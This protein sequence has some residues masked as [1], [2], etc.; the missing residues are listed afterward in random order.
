MVAIGSVELD[1]PVVLAPMAGVTDTVYRSICRRMGAGLVCSEMVSAEGLVHNNARTRTLLRTADDEHPVSMQMFGARPESMARAAVAAQE[2]GAD[3]IDVNAGC[4]TPKIVRNGAGAALLRDVPRLENILHAVVEYTE[5]PVTV[6]LRVGWDSGSVNVVEI[7]RRVEQCGVAA[8]SIHARTREQMFRGSADWR[9]IAEVVQ[10]VDIPVIGNGDVR[11]PQNGLR[12]M[13]ETGCAAVMI[14]RAALGNPWI[15]ERT[16]SYMGTGE[17]SHE[18]SLAER[19]DVLEQHICAAVAEYG[20]QRATRMMRK[21]AAWYLRGIPNAASF[22][23]SVFSAKTLAQ[24]INIIENMRLL[25]DANCG[26]C[27]SCG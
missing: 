16:A 20:E 8:V 4:P 2:E 12:M 11:T 19:L 22:R 21:H 27:S 7:A 10:A 23:K 5:R 3:I 6:K 25:S 18:P 9:F 13:D 14:G 26:V 17:M 1:N 15:F 24:Y